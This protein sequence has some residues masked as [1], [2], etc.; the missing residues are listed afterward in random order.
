MKEQGKPLF[1]DNLTKEQRASYVQ[2]AQ[3]AGKKLN[4]WVSEVLDREVA[5]QTRQINAAKFIKD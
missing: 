5:S 3:R 2:C 1:I 4:V